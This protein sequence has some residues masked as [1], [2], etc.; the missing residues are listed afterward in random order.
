[1]LPGLGQAKPH[2]QALNW[3]GGRSLDIEHETVETLTT[4]SGTAESP[5]S[6]SFLLPNQSPSS[7]CW[8][9]SGQEIK[10]NSIAQAS[11]HQEERLASHKDGP[12]LL[13]LLKASNSHP[14]LSLA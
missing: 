1:M 14:F 4:E 6:Q 5:E 13:W 8:K 2:V 3:G 11:L 12:S 9:L 7:R 10:L